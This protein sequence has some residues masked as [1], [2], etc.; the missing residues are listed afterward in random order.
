MSV[1]LVKSW[2]EG[3][4]YVVH[5]YFAFNSENNA[6]DLKQ[7]AILIQTIKINM[8]NVDKIGITDRYIEKHFYKPYKI[9]TKIK[10]LI[11]DLSHI[12]PSNTEDINQANELLQHLI[13]TIFNQ[14][15][16]IVNK[17]ILIEDSFNV[18][19][20]KFI[21]AKNMMT[22][23]NTFLADAK[24]QLNKDDFKAIE[25]LIDPIKKYVDN[26]YIYLDKYIDEEI[27]ATLN[28]YHPFVAEFERIHKKLNSI[29]E[30]V[31]RARSMADNRYDAH[32]PG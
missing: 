29:G 25:T 3:L 17:G 10:Y 1:E 21:I 15:Y 4:E 18:R 24:N 6:D 14:Y 26:K 23:L 20:E 5:K 27:Q 8:P 28:K 30:V 31:D 19:K 22:F 13:D 12:D 16:E 9:E 2:C 7:L 32:F 11:E